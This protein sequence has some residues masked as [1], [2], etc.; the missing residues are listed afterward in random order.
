ML[1]LRDERVDD[2]I[3]NARIARLLDPDTGAALPFPPPLFD[4]T[5]VRA[6]GDEWILAGFE[7]IESMGRVTDYAQSWTVSPADLL[8]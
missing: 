3:R 7:R 6:T 2:L 5:L 1:S 4:A 8:R